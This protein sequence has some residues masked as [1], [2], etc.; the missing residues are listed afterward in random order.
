MAFQIN[1]GFRLPD[2]IA[3]LVRNLHPNLKANIRQAFRL[4]ANDPYCG[5]PLKEEL[6]GLRSFRVKRFRIIYRIAEN[7]NILEIVAIGPRNSIY[8][9]TYKI[10]SKERF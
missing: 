3:T 7:D 6:S 4:I 9:E 8:E 2:D 5:K 10:I 1:Y